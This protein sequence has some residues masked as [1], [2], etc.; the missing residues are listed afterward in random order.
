MAHDVR[1]SALA[2]VLFNHFAKERRVFTKAGQELAVL[3]FHP[4]VHVQ[5]HARPCLWRRCDE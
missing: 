4:V 3:R 2:D 1:D 5:H